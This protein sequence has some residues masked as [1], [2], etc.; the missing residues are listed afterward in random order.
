M[1]PSHQLTNTF[2]LSFAESINIASYLS[3]YSFNLC[4]FLVCLGQSPVVFNL[5]TPKL[6]GH[7]Q[8]CIQISP[9]YIFARVM[10]TF[11]GS[12]I[13]IEKQVSQPPSKKCMRLSE[14]LK[15]PNCLLSSCYV[16]LY[17]DM[18]HCWGCRKKYFYN[19]I[20][21]FMRKSSVFH[22]DRILLFFFQTQL[23]F[24]YRRVFMIP[25]SPSPD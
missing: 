16:T 12:D 1:T 19:Y 9:L 22:A 15:S 4:K 11:S 13:K 21:S 6:R 2:G 3:L 24:S 8:H 18:S 14:Y 10:L 17:G 5:K 25:L 23:R 20:V 7:R